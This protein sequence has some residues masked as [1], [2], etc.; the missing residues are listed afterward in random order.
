VSLVV[1]HPGMVACT[2]RPT[3]EGSRAHAALAPMHY[4]LHEARRHGAHHGVS[5]CLGPSYI[6]LLQLCCVML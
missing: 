1:P 2:L 4:L 5:A 3:T 6:F